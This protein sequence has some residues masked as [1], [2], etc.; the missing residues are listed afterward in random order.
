M[1]RQVRSWRECAVDEH[2]RRR[3]D[4]LINDQ[5]IPDGYIVQLE[6]AGFE[7]HYPRAESR[8]FGDLETARLSLEVAPPVSVG[9]F[10]LG[11]KVRQSADDVLLTTEEA[12]E[13][14]G[15]SR[16]RV[17]AMVVNGVL[18]AERSGD[19]IR[20]SHASVQDYLVRRDRA[21][22]DDARPRSVGRFAHLFVAYTLAGD[23]SDA[24]VYEF[25]HEDAEQ[26]RAAKAFVD[27]V[28]EA[29]GE[30]GDVRVMS[31]R[32]AMSFCSQHKAGILP[33]E[34]FLRRR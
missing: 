26:M 19:S 30:S 21:G 12:G 23:Y 32:E 33:F 13:L 25:D 8:V 1:T 14:L 28:V 20:V 7:T 17:N 11:K 9:V 2:G 24:E 34:E 29:K 31:Y 10:P 16:Y 15:V 18:A 27:V 5:P 22:V 4:L 6:D 3:W